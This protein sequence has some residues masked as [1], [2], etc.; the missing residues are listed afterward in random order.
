[1]LIGGTNTVRL[2]SAVRRLY[3][4]DTWLTRHR[5][6]GD[7]SGAVLMDKPIGPGVGVRIDLS[8]NTGGSSARR[9]A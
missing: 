2:F 1:M 7:P 5:F 3:H 8:T 6:G 4:G 9:R